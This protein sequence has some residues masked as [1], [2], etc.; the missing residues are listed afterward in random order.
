MRTDDFI[1][2]LTRD[3]GSRPPPPGQVALRWLPGALAVMTAAFLAFFG[4]RSGLLTAEVMRPTAIKLAFGFLLAACAGWGA[5]RLARPDAPPFRSIW[6]IAFAAGF[7]GIVLALDQSW[8]DA[9][10]PR[11]TSPARCVVVIPLMGL[12]PLAALLH[13]MRQGAVTRPRIAGALAGAAAG[14]A[15]I[16]AY[17]LNCTEDSPLFIATWYVVA[18]ALSAGIGAFAGPRLLKW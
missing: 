1:G 18:A 15:A 17:A 5:L 11:W 8:H 13:A 10:S 6:P 14:G 2:V 12:L 16:L 7:I 9:P 4:L 3:L